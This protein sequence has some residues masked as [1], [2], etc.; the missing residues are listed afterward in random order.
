M[1][2]RGFCYVA[3]VTVLVTVAGAATVGYSAC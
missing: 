2:R 3:T 1:G